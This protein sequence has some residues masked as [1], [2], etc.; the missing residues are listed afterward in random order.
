MRTK[1]LAVIIFSATVVAVFVNNYYLDEAIEEIIEAVEELEIAGNDSDELSEEAEE[2]RSLYRARQTYIS[3]S[4][5]HGDLTDIEEMLSELAG[6]LRVGAM[7]E[8]EVTKGRLIDALWHLR[9][10]SGVNI[11]SVV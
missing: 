8:A 5:S 9:R 2:V 11:D 6:Q 7:E 10:L 4:V 3:L 1:I